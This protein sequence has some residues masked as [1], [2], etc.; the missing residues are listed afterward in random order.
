[1]ATLDLN[2]PRRL[3]IAMRKSCSVCSRLIQDWTMRLRAGVGETLEDSRHP[4][5]NARIIPL[6]PRD[7]H[8]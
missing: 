5:G 3:L 1:M 2:H 8:L 6:C 4:L 7:P